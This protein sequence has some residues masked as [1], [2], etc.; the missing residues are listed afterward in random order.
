MI[1]GDL[2]MNPQLHILVAVHHFNILGYHATFSTTSLDWNKLDFTEWQ[3]VTD[4]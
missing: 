3:H 1:Q 2:E 4:L